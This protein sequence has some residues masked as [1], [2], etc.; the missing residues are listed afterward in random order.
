MQNRPVYALKSVDNVLHLLAC[1][2]RGERLQVSKAAEELGVA[3]S[4]AHRLLAMLVYHGFAIHDADKSY[5]PGA[6]LQRMNLSAPP[7]SELPLTARPHLIALQEE[8]HETV[9]LM[10]LVGNEVNFIDSVEAE[11]EG[12]RVGTRKGASM[13]AHQTSG[14][15]ALLAE[16]S[17]ESLLALFPDGPPGDS[18]RDLAGFQRSLALIRGRGY[19]VNFGES[20]RGVTAVGSCIHGPD[21][22]SVAALAVSAPSHRMLRARVPEVARILSGHINNLDRDLA[23]DSHG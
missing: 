20:E 1:L 18:H 12:L 2:S 21:G 5:R 8:L 16:L 7:S 11:G 13:P 4:T 6:M 10:I 17:G 22:R 3:R 23:L 19:A 9:Q 14:G 15:K